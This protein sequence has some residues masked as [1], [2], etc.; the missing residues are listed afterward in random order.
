MKQLLYG[1][2]E[3]FDKTRR[4]LTELIRDRTVKR[5]LQIHL[6]VEMT[7]EVGLI[8]LKGMDL[9]KIKFVFSPALDLKGLIK[10]DAYKALL[11]R[12]ETVDQ[13]EIDLIQR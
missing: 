8:G 7:G 3:V 12:R 11:K 1:A 2:V 10:I 5:E 6:R 13:I 4:G 9:M